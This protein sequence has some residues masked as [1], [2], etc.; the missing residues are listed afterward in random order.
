MLPAALG[1]HSGACPEAGRVGGAERICAFGVSCDEL[2]VL[3]VLVAKGLVMFCEAALRL[4]A[5]RVLS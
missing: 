1:S 2:L 5:A 3:G 4:G